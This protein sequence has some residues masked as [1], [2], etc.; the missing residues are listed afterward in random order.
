M[1][2]LPIL[3]PASQLS[4]SAT[5]VRRSTDAAADA[6]LEANIAENGILQN[7]IGVPVARKKNQYRI[8]AGGRR[9]EA[10]HR[11]IQ[12]GHFDADYAVPVI[13]LG[14]AGDSIEIS[15]AE[16]FFQLTMNPAD[17]C[18][19]FQDIIET[20]G[21]S[22]ADVARRFGVTESFVRGRLRLAGLAEEIFAALEEGRITLEVA[23]AYASTADT[24]RQA[25]VF[26]QMAKGYYRSDVNEIRRQIASLS[27]R[28]G[29]PKALLIGREAYLAA[30]GRTDSDLFSDAAHELWLDTQIV[31]QLAEAA[32]VAAADAV[33]ARGEFAA[34]RVVTTT[35]IP[36]S[37]RS[38]LRPLYGEQPPLSPEQEAR[39]VEIERT[40]DALEGAQDEGGL[41]PSE[42][43][44]ER[45]EALE[46]ELAAIVDR[47]PVLSA[48]QKAG[49]I[50]FLV[51]GPDGQPC[52]A[53]DYYCAPA[54]AYADGDEGEAGDTIAKDRDDEPAEGKD[55][56]KPAISQRLADELAMMKSELLAAHV[57]SDPTFALDLGIF[58]MAENAVGPMHGLGLPSDL[59]ASAPTAPVHGFESGAQAATLW[60]DIDAGLDRSWLD[61]GGLEQRYDAFCALEETA[62]AAWLGWAIA[63]TLQ[64]VPAGRSGS[65]FLDHLGTKL[66][67]DVAAWWRPTARTYFDRISKTMILDLLADIGGVELRQRYG[68]SKKHDLAASAERLFAGDLIVEADIR[69]R[70]LNWLPDAM[71]FAP[72]AL[73]PAE[74]TGGG[75]DG[76][77]IPPAAASDTPPDDLADAA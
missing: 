33:R 32:M 12:K 75:A 50:A 25:A 10:V 7:L 49:A 70:A 4:K 15:L 34:V 59:R 62:R 2:S 61:A 45:I 22:P 60:Q 48:E 39:S 68:A 40:L 30:G 74:A 73:E 38:V 63:R 1:Q 43:A 72:A 57:A 41:E 3:I 8:I 69:D 67:I 19:A 13:L 14:K 35:N 28:A 52:I 54:A 26:E 5:N 36:Y 23:M 55:A 27:Y 65:G 58:I 44:L 71:R 20:D 16:N 17:A 29:D 21:A 53:D 9:L 64:A 46:D 56:G 76:E 24:D 6:R 47:D 18:R 37:E 42:E 31:D 11:L 51:I 77:G 66:A